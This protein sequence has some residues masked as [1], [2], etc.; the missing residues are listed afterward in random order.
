MACWPWIVPHERQGMDFDDFPYVKRWYEQM[1]TRPGVQ[2]GFDVLRDM[3]R[4]GAK[5]D[6]QAKGILFGQRA[7]S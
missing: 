6:D 1:K 4:A 5:M 3:R 7:Q 2:R